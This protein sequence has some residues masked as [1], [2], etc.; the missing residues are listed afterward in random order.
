MAG[1][2]RI[3]NWARL[4]TSMEIYPRNLGYMEAFRRLTEQMAVQADEALMDRL[5]QG[6]PQQAAITLEEYARQVQSLGQSHGLAQVWRFGSIS[7]DATAPGSTP[8]LSQAEAQ[9]RAVQHAG[10]Y[11]DVECVACGHPGL[12]MDEFSECQK[13]GEALIPFS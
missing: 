4:E 9:R 13:C 5:T 3:F 1:E 7:S 6:I 2:Y 10:R 8:L 12:Y 11:L